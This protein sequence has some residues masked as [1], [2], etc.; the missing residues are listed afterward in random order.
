MSC[1]YL[2]KMDGTRILAVLILA[3]GAIALVLGDCP[4]IQNPN[5]DF[6]LTCT[7]PILDEAASTISDES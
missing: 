7:P 3:C 5:P 1:V 2:V 4:N 6:S